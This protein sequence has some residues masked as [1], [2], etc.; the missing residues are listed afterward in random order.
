MW[1][2]SIASAKKQFGKDV[3]L[4]HLTIK[5]PA[6]GGKVFADANCWKVCSDN[7]YSSTVN[8]P[9]TN[10]GWQWT[11]TIG[12]ICAIL[13]TTVQIVSVCCCQ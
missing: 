8:V 12:F 11:Y 2:N 4:D 6:P 5:L 13:L 9:V 1:E 7:K 3:T 10:L